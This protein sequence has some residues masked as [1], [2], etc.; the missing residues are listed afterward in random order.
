MAIGARG[1]VEFAGF[2]LFCELDGMDGSAFGEA[3]RVATGE[4]GEVADGGIPILVEHGGV[5]ATAPGAGDHLFD[6]FKFRFGGWLVVFDVV[7]K[8]GNE[9]FLIFGQDERGLG[10]GTV[11]EAIEEIA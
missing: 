4:L 10:V 8:D 1:G 9:A 5:T 2:A 11:F 7:L 6:Q 3:E